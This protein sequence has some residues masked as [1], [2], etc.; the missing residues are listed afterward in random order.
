M[1]DATPD[2]TQ[3]VDQADWSAAQ[4]VA[5]SIPNSV[6]WHLDVSLLPDSRGYVALVAA[7]TKGTSCAASDLWIA[8]SRDGLAW[9]TFAIPAFWRGMPIARSRSISTWYR[10]TLRYD[11]ATD[12]L[13]LWPSALAGT[14]CS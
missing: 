4:P 11:A 14:T 7:Y 1:R 3:R 12:S 9:H 2:T 6:V 10:G 13:H 8:T 5:L